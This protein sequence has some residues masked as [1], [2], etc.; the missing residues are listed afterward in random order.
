MQFHWGTIHR[1]ACFSAVLVLLG[2]ASGCGGKGKVSGAVT[3]PDGQ[4]LPIG[5]ITFTPASGPGASAEIQDGKYTAEDVTPG[6]YKVFVETAYVEQGA[7]LAL[8]GVNLKGVP[9]AGGT[10]GALPKD[11]P[12]EAVAGMAK[13]NKARD[14]GIKKARD[15]LAKYRPIPEKFTDPKTSGL[16]LTV[17]SGSNTF[18][19]DLSGKK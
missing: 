18:P 6:D 8:K 5:R 7:K 15:D 10:G 3:G 1:V 13:I 12:P 11:A 17:K 19:V 16:S 4:P 9:N 2:A 14:E